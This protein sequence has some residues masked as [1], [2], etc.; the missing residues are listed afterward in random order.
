MTADTPGI[1]STANLT[2]TVAPTVAP[3]YTQIILFEVVPSATAAVPA[4]GAPT[5]SVALAGNSAN[6]AQ[7]SSSQ[8]PLTATAA[9]SSSVAGTPG[10]GTLTGCNTTLLFPYIANVAG[11][12]T[13]VAVSN[14]SVG[15]NVS[16]TIVGVA[17]S[18][19][20]TLTKQDGSCTFTFYGGGATANSPIVGSPITVPAGTTQSFL[21]SNAAPGFVGYAVASCTFQGGHGFAFITDG[22]GGGGRGLSQGYLAIVLQNTLGGAQ[23]IPNGSLSIPE[24]SR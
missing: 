12:D 23:N 19:S 16:G 8:T 2:T 17:G 22:F 20:N 5:V 1:D 7:F 24:A 9:S 18:T 21:L 11:Y 4:S 3:P 15:T 14:A 10:P 6:Y 13:G